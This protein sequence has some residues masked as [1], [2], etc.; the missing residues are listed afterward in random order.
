MKMK[1]LFEEYKEQFMKS[2]TEYCCYCLEPKGE[3]I[4]CCHENHFVTFADLDE[5]DQIYLIEEELQEAF[6]FGEKK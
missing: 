6:D 1:S 3:K 4:G 2:E 5:E